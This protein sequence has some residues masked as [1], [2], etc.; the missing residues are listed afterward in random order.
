[1]MRS[2]VQTT[3]VLGKGD[4]IHIVKV[5]NIIWKITIPVKIGVLLTTSRF[6]SPRKQKLGSNT[7]D[8]ATV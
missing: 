3:L 8:T 7:T 1:M 6:S 4:P 5:S 2:G